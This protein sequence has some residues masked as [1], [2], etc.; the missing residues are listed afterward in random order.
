ME[1][2][3]KWLIALTCLIVLGF[4]AIF[5]AADR[6]DR[7]AKTMEAKRSNS[8]TLCRDRLEELRTG[9]TSGDDLSV[10]TNCV[11]NGFLSRSAVIDALQNRNK[12]PN[13]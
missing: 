7:Q 9:K 1:G 4:T 13:G 6:A 11:L 8:E 5:I 3:V 12:R 2:W 10:L